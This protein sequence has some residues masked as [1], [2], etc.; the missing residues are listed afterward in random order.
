[1]PIVCH[2]IP[3][4]GVFYVPFFTLFLTK[5]ELVIVSD[6]HWFFIVALA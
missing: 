6:F 5:I 3:S 1:L 4:L 2:F